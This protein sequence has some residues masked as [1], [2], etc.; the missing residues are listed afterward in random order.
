MYTEDFY[1]WQFL[2]EL[3]IML[4]YWLP[5]VKAPQSKPQKQSRFAGLAFMAARSTNCVLLGEPPFPGDLPLDLP[6]YAL[7]DI[8]RGELEI[9][10]FTPAMA[11]WLPRTDVDL[12]LLKTFIEGLDNRPA[13]ESI[14]YARRLLVQAGKL[15]AP[16]DAQIRLAPDLRYAEPPRDISVPAET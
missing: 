10:A 11:N 5:Q 15:Q 7:T 9:V 14:D 2:Q 16:T 3:L 1:H 6:L 13:A 4:A 12:S 8:Q